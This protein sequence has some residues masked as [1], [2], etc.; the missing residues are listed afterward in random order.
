MNTA[1]QNTTR[2]AHTPTLLALVALLL[3]LLALAS[4]FHQIGSD[5]HWWHMLTGKVIVDTGQV[6][7]ADLFSFTHNGTSWVNWE[8]L[9]GVVM[10]LLYDGLGPA[11]LLLF[12]MMCLLGTLLLL[13]PLARSEHSR[14]MP[15]A[16]GTACILTCLLL[17]S[18]QNR[19]GDRPYMLGYL[20]LAATYALLHFR[21]TIGIKQ[22]I[23]AV[24]LLLVFLLWSVSHPSWILGLA[25]ASA[26]IADDLFLSFR[27]KSSLTDAFRRRMPEIAAVA[28][29][30]LIIGIMHGFGGYFGSM[31]DIFHTSLLSE[32]R[33]MHQVFSFAQPNYPAFAILT[34]AWIGVTLWQYRKLRPVYALFM[35][36]LLAY[37]LKYY[38]FSAV[39]SICATAD[40]L[41]MVSATHVKVL[42]RRHAPVMFIL[43]AA[44]LT[45]PLLSIRPANSMPPGVTVDRRSVT[46]DMAD[47]MEREHIGGNLIC[48]SLGCHSYIA[49][50]LWPKVH[51]FIDGRI[52]QVFSGSFL[53]K[54]AQTGEGDHLERILDAYPVSLVAM[55]RSINNTVNTYL[56]G[57]LLHRKDFHLLYF[58]E[59]SALFASPAAGAIPA[60]IAAFRLLNP[61]RLSAEQLYAEIEK[62]QGC[63]LLKEVTL[64]K[65]RAPHSKVSADVIRWLLGLPKLPA[66]IKKEITR[67]VS[68]P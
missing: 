56:A 67:I 60:D 68:T 21:N 61:W 62:D 33:P 36:A 46:V 39:F 29:A 48:T 43:V 19:I 23:R 20:L 40:L 59:V 55:D 49:Y 54:Y 35:L 14:W 9:P 47:F 12:R 45:L 16:V 8:W 17:L 22:Y 41:R 42:Q 34:L 2:W 24:I 30:A 25:I 52:P 64:L 58:D 63:S 28:V 6:P 4:T 10:Y 27:Q 15:Q 5:D 57:M 37:A 51:I 50:R 11:G 31:G 7:Q 44:L 13:L 18:M 65:E 26:M 3:T 53:Q 1:Q 38:R 66:D 32:W